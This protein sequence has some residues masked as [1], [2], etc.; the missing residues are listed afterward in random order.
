MDHLLKEL[1]SF[2]SRERG[3]L[4][5]GRELESSES[6][7]GLLKE[8]QSAPVPSGSG[9]FLFGEGGGEVMEMMEVRG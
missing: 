5:V 4:Q 2:L 1:N 7:I 9:A 8:Q 3:H 6:S